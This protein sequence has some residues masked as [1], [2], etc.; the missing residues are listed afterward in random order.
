MKLTLDALVVLDAIAQK[1]SFAAAANALYR[2]PST[3]TYSVQKLE[4]D[5][6]FVIFR[7][8][9]RRSVL[10]PAGK[11]LLEQ[12]RELLLAADRIVENAHKVDKGWESSLNI[13]LD[14]L[15]NAHEFYPLVAEFY[16]L[17]TG[18]QISISEEVMGGSLESIADNRADIVIGSPPPVNSIKGVKFQQISSSKWLFVVARGHPLTKIKGVLTEED[19]APYTSIVIKDSSRNS[20][21]M[22]HRVFDKRNQLRVAT[23]E[24]KII[25]QIQGLGVGFLPEH[26]IQEHLN[27][28]TLIALPVD[29]FSDETPQ[30]C[31]WRT[32]NKGKAMRWFLDRLL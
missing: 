25:A 13:T 30:Y 26:K 23:M 8:E 32:N 15:W 16:E 24:Q 29:K 22:A 18:V 27:N 6:G 1:G 7:R 14:T 5:L 9:G 2:V 4:E 10:T 19:I 21:I 3:V 31:A 17:N 28:K 11:V 12:G 20:P